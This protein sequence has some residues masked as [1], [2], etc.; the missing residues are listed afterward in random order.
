MASKSSQKVQ[1]C[2]KVQPPSVFRGVKAHTK[3]QLFDRRLTCT[4][5]WRS[6]P[7]TPTASSPRPEVTRLRARTST[8][9]KRPSSRNWPLRLL[10]RL[11]VHNLLQF[12]KLCS[13]NCQHRL[14]PM[15]LVLRMKKMTRT[16][17]TSKTTPSWNTYQSR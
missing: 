6:W 9:V 10:Q 2:L 11:F 12:Q 13:E 1:D 8:S 3:Q 14:L 17:W 16:R 5:K 15:E 4:R 7:E